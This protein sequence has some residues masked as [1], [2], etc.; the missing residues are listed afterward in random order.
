MPPNSALPTDWPR[1]RA[2]SEEAVAEPRCS[3]PTEPLRSHLP[4]DSIEPLMAAVA[5]SLHNVFLG[6]GVLV[7]IGFTMTF[8]LR[9]GLSP[10]H[11]APDKEERDRRRAALRVGGNE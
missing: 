11:A 10:H 3:R 9:W 4:A 6:T 7:L 1:M 8:V 2:K 5:A